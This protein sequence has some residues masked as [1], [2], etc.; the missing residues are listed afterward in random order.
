MTDSE[1]QTYRRRLVALAG[2][3]GGEVSQLRDE[4]LRGAGGEASGGLSDTP[5]HPADLA[6]REFEEGTLLGLVGNE[7]QFLAEVNEALLRIAR[8]D[9]GRCEACGRPISRSRLRAIPYARSCAGCAARSEAA[10]PP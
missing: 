10:A 6:G 3:L 2:R 4:A 5:I 7:E 1:I 9:F 8:G